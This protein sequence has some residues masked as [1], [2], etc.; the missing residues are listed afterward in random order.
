M[1]VLKDCRET[2]IDQLKP[3]DRIE[4]EQ[5][6]SAARENQTI[7]MKGRFIRAERGGH[8]LHFHRAADEKASSNLLLLELHD[9]E[10]TTVSLG[11]KT[12]VRH[13]K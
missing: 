11:P 3:G 7:T 13:A 12:V 10:F 8:G 1:S 6:V 2:Q 5:V 4:V 9:G